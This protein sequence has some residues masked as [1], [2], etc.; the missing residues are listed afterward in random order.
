MYDDV[1]YQVSRKELRAVFDTLDA[2][3]DGEISHAEFIKVLLYI[4]L[5][6]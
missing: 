3:H 5:Y 2:N 1:T 4:Y 6:I